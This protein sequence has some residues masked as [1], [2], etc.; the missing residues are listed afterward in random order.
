MLCYQANGTAKLPVAT[1]GGDKPAPEA[2][3]K[4]G[5]GIPSPAGSKTTLINSPG[6]KPKP[7]V[8]KPQAAKPKP[9]SSQSNKAAVL[10]VDTTHVQLSDDATAPT[11]V[12]PPRPACVLLGGLFFFLFFL[13]IDCGHVSLIFPCPVFYFDVLIFSFYVS[14][15]SQVS[16]QLVQGSRRV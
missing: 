2:A 11:G 12:L 3:A 6:V 1:P 5:S 16:Y 9:S 4:P 10:P 13:L 7:Q 14:L 8:P 15:Y